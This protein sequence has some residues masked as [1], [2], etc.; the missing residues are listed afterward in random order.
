M[1]IL[2]TAGP[3]REPIDPVRYLSNRS[4]GKMGYAL[5][6]VARERGHDVILISGPVSLHPPDRVE[7]VNVET[8]QEMYDA[9]GEAIGACEAAIFCAAVADYRVV[10]TAI[11]KIKKSSG[12]LT[13]T[14]TANPDILGSCREKFGFAGVLVGFAAETEELLAHARAKLE[15]KGCDLLVANDVGRKD[16]GFDQSHN[17]VTLLFRSGESRWIPLESKEKI[18]GEILAEVERLQAPGERG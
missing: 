12:E 3:T 6:T 9:V 5:A 7:V 2:I 8:A 14:L 13:L 10:D 4:S 1:R 18:A 15:R 11:S 16:I 17:E